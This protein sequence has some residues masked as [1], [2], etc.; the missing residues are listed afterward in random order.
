MHKA[1]RALK[2]KYDMEKE[3]KKIMN[4]KWELLPKNLRNIKDGNYPG[5][6]LL[7]FTYKNLKGKNVE[8]KDIFYVGMTNAR[9]GLTGRIQQFVNGI[10]KNTSHSAG[11][12]FYEEYSNG[13]PFSESNQRKKFYLV[14]LGFECNVNKSNR[15]PNDL[16]IMGEICRLEYYIIAL[17]LEKTNKEPELNKK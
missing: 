11:M 2:N 8:L 5:I 17:I 7:A 3:I 13:I 4:K 9:K 1:K 14:S 15:K 16:R 6:Y 10:E 12:R